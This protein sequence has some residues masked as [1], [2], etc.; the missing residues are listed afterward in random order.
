MHTKSI[1]SLLLLCLIVMSLPSCLQ[2]GNLSERSV[3]G[4]V[5]KQSGGTT[6]END[7]F[8]PPQEAEKKLADEIN[9]GEFPRQCSSFAL[10]LKEN[11]QGGS[12]SEKCQ[13]TQE[14]FDTCKGLYGNCSQKIVVN[15]TAYT[16][17]GNVSDSSLSRALFKTSSTVGVGGSRG[18]GTGA[19]GVP[20]FSLEMS[21]LSGVTD[22]CDRNA[23]MLSMCNTRSHYEECSG[24]EKILPTYT[25][26]DD[27]AHRG[28]EQCAPYATYYS[29]CQLPCP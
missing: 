18:G 16:S 1:L 7:T 2:P 26:C 6:G 28:E 21:F 3:A 13:R 12:A 9:S 19:E 4:T 20:D 14:Y 22:L 5:T 23:L 29:Q 25:Y 15:R 11:C 10:Y 24:C 27:V 17:Q 8:V